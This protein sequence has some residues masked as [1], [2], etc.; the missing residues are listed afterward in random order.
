MLVDVLQ[1]FGGKVVHT[2]NGEI[3]KSRVLDGSLMY[4]FLVS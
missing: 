3:A 2:I 1:F 4:Q